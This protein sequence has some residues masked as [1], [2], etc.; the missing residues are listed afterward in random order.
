MSQGKE[1]ADGYRPLVHLHQLARDIVNG[2]D[3][4]GINRMAQAKPVDDKSDAKQRG[5][6]PEADE[7]PYPGTDIKNRE[8]RID[9]NEARLEIRRALVEKT[10][11]R[12]KHPRILSLDVHMS[13]R[14]P[15]KAI[16]YA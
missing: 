2:G 10:F 4:I 11:D 15:G 1:K 5:L 9:Q 13:S 8:K 7:G 3:V 6:V 14:K 12:G 16:R